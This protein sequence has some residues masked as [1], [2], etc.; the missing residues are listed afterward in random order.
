MKIWRILLEKE[1]ESF[2]LRDL[3]VLSFYRLEC[4]V[5]AYEIKGLAENVFRLWQ[6]VPQEE[7]LSITEIPEPGFLLRLPKSRLSLFWQGEPSYSKI[8]LAPQGAFGSGLHPT[9]LLV[10]Y[11]LDKLYYQGIKPKRI[12]DWGAG[13]GI[14]SLVAARLFPQSQVLALDIDFDSTKKCRENV[15]RNRLEAQILSFCAPLAA[16]K[17][18]F[19]LILANIFL[20]VL[21]E[22]APLVKDRL[23]KGGLLVASG[24]LKESTSFLL[25]LYQGFSFLELAD[26]EGWQ[27]IIWQKPDI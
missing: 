27:A 16:V 15:I 19:D 26:K 13:S 20:R 17:G 24:F 18:S 2:L 11:L 22:D 3:E 10:L 21:T 7:G 12:L 5:L 25:N 14:L 6:S 9:T 23:A 8:I 4:G 1:I